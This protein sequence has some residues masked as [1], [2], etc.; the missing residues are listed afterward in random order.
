MNVNW[1]GQVV[2]VTGGGKGIGRAIA[3][4]LAQ[5]GARVAV[6]GRDK[7]ALE[8]VA[9]EIQGFAVTMD[10]R[11]ENSVNTAVEAVVAWGGKLDVLVNNAGI[12]LLVT[13]LMETSPKQWEDVI[14]TNLT[15]AFLATRAAWPHLQKS[16]GQILNLSSVAGTR[17]FHGASAYCASKFGINGFTEVLKAEGA[18]FGIRVM[19]FCPAAI[20][21]EIWGEWATEEDKSRMMTPDQIGEL[22]STML[23]TPRNIDLKPWIIENAR[24]PFR[25][26]G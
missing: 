9:Q 26:N 15:G 8:S 17:G 13:P 2:L 6:S 24:D 19:S 18:E 12:G 10:V 1:Q 16:K 7:G 25:A 22:V 5:R 23:S 4:A 14:A 3:M 20:S 21:T 11:D